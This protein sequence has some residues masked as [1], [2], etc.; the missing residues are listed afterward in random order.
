MDAAEDPATAEAARQAT[1]MLDQSHNIE[2]SLEGIIQSVMNT[3]TAYAK[4][5]LVDRGRLAA[6]HAAGDVILANR[7]VMEAYETDVRPLLARYASTWAG[8][9]T[10]SKPF[11][12][13]AI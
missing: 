9:L 13:A 4:A 1:Y 3:Q 7:I 10:P 6:A 8:T 12:R 5:L 2:G 11:E